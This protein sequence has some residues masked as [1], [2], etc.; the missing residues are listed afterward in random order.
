MFLEY[1]GWFSESKGL[2][3]HEDLVEDLVKRDGGF[4]ATLKSGKRLRARFVLAAPGIAHYKNFPRWARSVPPERSVHA[5]DLV[6]LE[7]RC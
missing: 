7:E 6:W 5:C 4:E 3:A 1:A 2:E